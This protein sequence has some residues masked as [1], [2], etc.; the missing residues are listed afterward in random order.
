MEGPSCL[1]EA[2]RISSADLSST[3]NPDGLIAIAL[4]SFIHAHETSANDSMCETNLFLFQS[5]GVDIGRSHVAE[6]HRRVLRIKAHPCEDRARETVA[7]QIHDAL[8]G[9]A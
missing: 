9:A 1:I 6:Q 7:L 8:R 5:Q 4:Y 2:R 3:D